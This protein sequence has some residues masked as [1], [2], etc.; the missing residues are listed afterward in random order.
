MPGFSPNQLN[1]IE[2]EVARSDPLDPML[3]LD[4]NPQWNHP[5]GQ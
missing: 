2:E 1:L 4:W 3:V 5:Q